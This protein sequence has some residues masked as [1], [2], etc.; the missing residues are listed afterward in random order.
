VLCG[1]LV[2]SVARTLWH[3][4]IAATLAFVAAYAIGQSLIPFAKARRAIEPVF[5]AVSGIPLVTLLPVFL[6]ALR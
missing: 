3:T 4:T 6:L 2:E 5:Q 1:T